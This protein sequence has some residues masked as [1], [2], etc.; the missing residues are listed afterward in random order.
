MDPRV[1]PSV[2][3]KSFDVAVLAQIVLKWIQEELNQTLGCRAELALP[4]LC[5]V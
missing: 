3:C 5:N 4:F 2:G 1:C